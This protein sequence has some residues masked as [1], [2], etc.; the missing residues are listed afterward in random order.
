M[1]KATKRALA[2]LYIAFPLIAFFGIY[3]WAQPSQAPL[4]GNELVN[5]QTSGGS[6]LTVPISAVRGSLAARTVSATTGTQATT[7]ADQAVILTGAVTALTVTLPNPASN[8][9]ELQVA[10]STA[11]GFTTALTVTTAAGSQTQA[12][13]TTYNG[14]T[15]AAGASIV[16]VYVWT[17]T[18][19]NGTWYR[20][21]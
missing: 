5:I 10:N 14:Q 1:R 17:A 15:L 13:N 12:L 21:Q 6:G 4:S 11:A 8:G 16:F 9:E 7:I 20:V 2:A 19:G 18:S 3:G